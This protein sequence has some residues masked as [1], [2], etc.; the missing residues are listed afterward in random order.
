M[1]QNMR[2]T[3]GL[4]SPRGHEAPLN[5][6]RKFFSHLLQHLIKTN[7]NDSFLNI[8]AVLRMSSNRTLWMKISSNDWSENIVM[9]HFQED[10]WLEN[11]RMTKQTF[12]W[13]CNQLEAKNLNLMKT[14]WVP[15]NQFLFKN[16]LP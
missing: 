10:E 9:K 3:L 11:F 13:L 2:L 4:T 12:F 16:K 5:K 1:F 15:G 8:G 14:V 6:N 7:A